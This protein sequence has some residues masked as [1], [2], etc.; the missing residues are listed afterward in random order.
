MD[1]KFI[2]D[3]YRKLKGSVYLDKTV[4]FLRM[5]IV[6]FERGEVE[7]KIE[8]I[9]E[10]LR[11]EAKW[12]I[13]KA[14]I[15]DTIQVLTFPK[16]IE[17]KS[18]NAIEGEPI[19]ISNIS[20]TDVMIEKYNNFIDMSVEGHILGILWILTIGY[21]MDNDL[22]R[23]CYG[24][25]LND[26]L[27]FDNQKTT[28]SPSLFKPY[29][30]QYENW[31]NQGLK[32]AEGIVNNQ[33]K[34]VIITILDLTRYYYNIEIT[35][36]VFG[37]MTNMFF[38]NK[39]DVL[40][41][42]NYCI[43]D[44]IKTYSELCGCKNKY[45]LP[46]GF[47]PSSIISN[48]YLKNIDVEISKSEG[49]VY[50]GRYVDDMILV[51]E[52]E[53]AGD[54][55]EKISIYGNQY[56][57]DYMIELLE[58]SNILK[59]NNEG[60]YLLNEFPNLNFQKSKFRFFYIDKDGYDTIIEKIQADIYKNSSEFNY[61]P[62][63]AIEELNTDIIK[64]ER[65]DTVNKLRAINKSTIDKYSLSKTVG[66][67]IM[68]SKFAEGKTVVK[69]A[70]SL[71]Q[72][73]N[74]KEILSNYTLWESI[75]NYYVINDY[76]EGVSYL[77]KAIGSAIEHM[78]EEVNKC[79]EYKYLKS[80]QIEKVGDS[81]IYYYLAC[82]TRATAISWGSD[83]KQ[84]IEESIAVFSNI[85]KYKK[86][87]GLYTLKN[88]KQ[89]RKSYC[90]SRMINKSLLPINIEDCMSAFTPNDLANKGNLFTLKNYL[91]SDLKCRFSKKNQKY[92]PYIQ[93]PFEILYSILINQIREG[94][95][96]LFS[97]QKCV[98]M[99]CKKYAE[100]FGKPNGRYIKSYIDVDFYDA[101]NHIVK[102]KSKKRYKNSKVKIAV[103]N[104]RM[105]EADID[106]I[107]KG[108]IRDVSKRCREIGRI[109]NEAIRYK[110]D[111]LIFPEA[112]IPLE[113]LKILQAKVADHNMVII[114]GIEHIKQGDLVYN[115]TA[116]ILPM[117]NKY[118][119]YAIP[120]FH[121]KLY[122]SPYELKTVKKYGCKPAIG[123]RHTLFNWGDIFFATY[124]CYELTS[125]SLRHTFQG[126]A[127][128]IFGVEWNKD[129]YYFGNIMEALSRDIYCYCVQ[130]NMSEYGD[131]RIIQPTKKDLMNILKVKGGINAS[132]LIGEIDIQE[133][134]VHQKNKNDISDKSVYK[135]LPAGWD[136]TKTNIKK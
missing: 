71:E 80:Y 28:A 98:E 105:E 25:R 56:V 69:F 33:K 44:V 53:N 43:Y 132:V 73:L 95:K 67:N 118:M 40:N 41:R 52:V 35:E 8:Y 136:L 58:N 27:V 54:F 109:L 55:K 88:I 29:F 83:I 101:E 78:D 87:K 26:N 89:I 115:L 9:Y 10:A 126:T 14:N 24:N 127:D 77:S 7:K 74:H 5:R 102:I 79:N 123:Q 63:T 38:D 121:Q 62:E 39:D 100:N 103:A 106:D 34:S 4:P 51:T 131:S 57:C 72:V 84:A 112:Y 90:N 111:I 36:Q 125:I 92:A 32:K 82:L 20:G 66:K 70:K 91:E 16:T 15:L 12:E 68:M 47:L 114:C 97:D 122:F 117:K 59:S 86:Y 60:E 119:S 30:S 99:L 113:Y 61:I 96:E 31:R 129:T 48:Y 65:E 22:Y 17:V 108:N 19:V 120:F 45:M 110:A 1:K 50:Y 128:I 18:D 21:K 85:K 130:S 2:E 46:I 107:L 116:T 104:V 3:A 135:P 133:L 37:N 42:L 75:L 124:C 76:I 13:F 23:N 81:L 11:D 49:A 134:R 93:S 64:I 94:K 6:D